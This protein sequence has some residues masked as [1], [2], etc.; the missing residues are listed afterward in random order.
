MK[1]YALMMALAA[2]AYTGTAQAAALI[3]MQVI[4]RS[5]GL[6]LPLISHQG[7]H[8][9]IGMPGERY[10]IRL[11]NQTGARVMG[12][13]SVDGIN[14]IS[15]ETAAAAQTGYVLSP[16]ESAEISGWRK[17]QEQ[18][19]RF[20]FTRLPD[21]YAA[22]TDRPDN[23]GVI[24]LAAFREYVE[25]VARPA[26]TPYAAGRSDAAADR[27]AEAPAVTAPEQSASAPRAKMAEQSRLGTGHGERE[28]SYIGYTEFRRA[29]PYPEESVSIYYDSREQLASRGIL[30]RPVPCCAVPQ[31]FPANPPGM[32][33]PDPRG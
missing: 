30:P 2:T 24:G 25:P 13:L 28:T 10:S 4:S 26:P 7:K 33:V 17:S 22:R 16:F 23:V 12:V 6:P 21:S 18:V 1:R 31:P 8:Y 15:G 11:T 3:D 27:K 19:A 32:F 5:T 14:A 20:Y 29:T 9:V